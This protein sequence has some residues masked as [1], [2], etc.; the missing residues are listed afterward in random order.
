MAA[1]IPQ[2]PSYLSQN[3]STRRRE[4]SFPS[5]QTRTS[6]SLISP[7]LP[8]TGGGGAW[9]APAP[10]PTSLADTQPAFGGAA[11]PG[12][13]GPSLSFALG[14]GE[15]DK[16]E[17]HPLK[18]TWDVYFSHRS[19]GQNKGQQKKEDQSVKPG[20]EKESRE[21]WEGAV[22]KLGG[23]S[24][25]ESLHPFLAHLTPSSSLPASVASSVH[26]FSPDS[27]SI[28]PS[29]NVISDLNI[30]RSP[31]AP[32]WED[33]ANTGGGRWVLRLRK[34]VA[35]RVWEEVVF[36]LVGERIVSES[37]EGGKEGKVNGVVLSVRKDE[38][39]LS[40]WCAPTSRHERDTIRDSL[41]AALEPLLSSTASMN[42]QLD[43]KP[44]P[45]NGANPSRNSE[46]NHASSPS[47]HASPSSREHHNGHHSHSHSHSHR[48]REHSGRSDNHESGRERQR[49]ENGGRGESSGGRP[50]ARTGFSSYRSSNGDGGEREYS[51]RERTES[52][53]S[54]S[55]GDGTRDGSRGPRE[56]TLTWG[57]SPL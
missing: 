54:R 43:Y 28:P 12:K 17:V 4:P 14:G 29:P 39:I 26:L 5:L 21:E 7:S 25:I 2:R 1:S 30:F 35:D 40:L 10:S 18:Y 52:Y 49:S 13:K 36:A 50:P 24:S 20:K 8:S 53:N 41:R 3:S 31:I 37:D 42:L 55:G 11:R 6:S 51:H 9:G 16:S 45:V 48:D 44:H 32:M 56:S 38:D 33:P 46:S 19:A 27:D 15:K 34:G 22:V 23:F 57:R 47:H